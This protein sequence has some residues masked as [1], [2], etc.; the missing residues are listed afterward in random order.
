MPPARILPIERG[1]DIATV[2]AA[3]PADAGCAVARPVRPAAGGAF[4]E[5]ARSVRR[6][7]HSEGAGDAEAV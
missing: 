4:A 3:L 7:S 5:R 2:P 1:P 6:R